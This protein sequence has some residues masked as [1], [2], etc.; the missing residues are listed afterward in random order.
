MSRHQKQQ[1]K[2]AGDYSGCHDKITMSRHRKRAT[3]TFKG[4]D[5]CRDNMK[6]KF[7]DVEL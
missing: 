5:W 1:L 4:I 7:Q 6:N 2:A 3:K